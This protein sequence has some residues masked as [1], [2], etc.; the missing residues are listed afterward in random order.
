MRRGGAAG[1]GSGESAPMASKRRAG[2]AYPQS[3][4][5]V[6]A[7][8]FLTWCRIEKGLTAATIS[9]Y[10]EDLR[11][12]TEYCPPEDV[13]NAET[14]HRYVDSLYAAGLSS[15]SIARHLTTLR[16]FYTFLLQEGN[17]QQDA[18]HLMTLPRQWSRLP[19]F[20]SPEQVDALLAAPDGGELNGVRDRAM[21]EFLYA[22]GLRVSELCKVEISGLNT[23]LGVVRVFGKGQ[24]ERLVPVGKSALLQ[25]ATYL[26]QARPALLRGQASRYLFVTGRGTCMTRQGFWKLLKRYGQQVGIWHNLTPH[27]LRHSFATHMLERG[28]DLRSVQMLLGHAD[29]STTEIY[30][31]LSRAGLRKAFEEHHPREAGAKKKAKP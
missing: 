15:R 2:E 30:T 27:T 5:A 19:K 4:L 14:L 11:R 10:C 18:V 26:E 1:A 31:H 28:A 25:V 7:G 24:K 6:W 29:I 13:E 23:D 17:V 8:A 21:L 3:R 20:L 16:G 22:T 9:A 12:F